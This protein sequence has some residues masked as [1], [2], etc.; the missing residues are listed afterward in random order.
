MENWILLHGA[1]GNE[2]DFIELKQHLSQ[3]VNIYTFNFECHGYEEKCTNTF[4]IEKFAENLEYFIKQNQIENPCIFGYS[5]GG[6]VALYAASTYSLPIK[7]IIT[8]GTK[9]DWNETFIA[10]QLKS[11][12][13][14]KLEEKVPA[15][16]SK[17]KNKFGEVYWSQIVNNTAE[18]MKDL[19]NKNLLDKIIAG[20]DIPVIFLLGEKD[21]M[22]TVDETKFICKRVKEGQFSILPSTYH[23]I[24]MVDTKLLV[25]YFLNN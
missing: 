17:L 14:D 8:L 21:E 25:P 24:E 15:F 2:N 5:M 10:K 16:A 22:V 3:K 11:L 20:I 19:G 4:S 1:L 6:Y 23:P 18:M 9:F 13:P 7:K 12:N